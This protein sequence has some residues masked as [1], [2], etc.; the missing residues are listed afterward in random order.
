MVTISA[1]PVGIP[2]GERSEPTAIPS[3][4]EYPCG[5]QTSC[6]HFAPALA[7]AALHAQGAP[8]QVCHHSPPPLPCLSRDS[9]CGWAAARKLISGHIPKLPD[10]ARAARDGGA[11]PSPLADQGARGPTPTPFSPPLADIMELV[12]PPVF[13]RH[14]QRSR[15]FA[16]AAHP[17]H[18]HHAGDEDAGIEF[19]VI[20]TF[21]ALI[22]L[23]ITAL[24]LDN[25][26]RLLRRHAALVAE[27]T[28]PPARALSNPYA[29]TPFLLDLAA[30]GAGSAATFAA[31]YRACAVLGAGDVT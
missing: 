30:A 1:S 25:H 19:P 24:T 5:G 9:A 20:T 18:H 2:P 10:S 4:D 31:A 29:L 23:A 22:T 28:A 27:P 8:V 14:E 17:S 16:S 11:A 7:P 13:C 6:S 21:F 3:G 15:D 12:P 26:A